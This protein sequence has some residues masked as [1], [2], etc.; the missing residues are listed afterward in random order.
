MRYWFSSPGQPKMDTAHWR[1]QTRASPG[2]AWV[3]FWSIVLIAYHNIVLRDDGAE[4]SNG[5][6]RRLGGGAGFFS[7]HKPSARR[8][9]RLPG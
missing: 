8:T 4:F 1:F 5:K 2:I 3:K 7:T 6:T 9:C